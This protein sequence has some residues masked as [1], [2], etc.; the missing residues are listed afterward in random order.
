MNIYKRIVLSLFLLLNCLLSNISTKASHFYGAD[1]YYSHVIGN[2]YKVYLVV[3]GDCSGT[4]FPS[5]PGSTPEVIVYN[6]GNPFDTLTLSIQAGSNV[7]VT[8]V[9]NN[10]INNTVCSNPL[11]TVPGVKRF[12][13]AANVT[14]NALSAN[15]LFQFNGVMGNSS[16]GRSNSITNITVGPTGSIIALT[17]TLNNLSGPNSSPVYTTI[18][19]P[20]FC[21]NK[22]NRCV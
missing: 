9:C 15:W 20:F 5:F 6:N 7:E 17:A 1:F 2:T 4:S 11:S 14:L 3:Y 22:C 12:I 21:I 16:A 10:Q 19:T 8:P 18:P 13:Y